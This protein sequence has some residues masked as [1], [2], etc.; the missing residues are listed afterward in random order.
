MKESSINQ[1]DNFSK[2]DISAISNRII[3]IRKNL[4]HLTQKEFAR[5]L[6][7]SQP[8]LSMIESGKKTISTETVLKINMIYGISLQYVLYGV[9]AGAGSTHS[10]AFEKN[11]NQIESLKSLQYA[12]HL[13]QAD[14]DLISWYC[15]LSESRRHT[16]RESIQ[17]IALSFSSLSLNGTP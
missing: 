16:L 9:E 5:S 15:A 7:V 4:L 6:G 17:D 11:Y 13:Q 10:T 3:S 12:F 14:I 2:D 1:F 8:Y